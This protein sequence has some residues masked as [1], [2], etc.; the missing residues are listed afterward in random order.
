MSNADI[1]KISPFM[2]FFWE[3]QQNYLSCLSTTVR[4]HPMVIRYCLSLASKSAAA[5]DDMRYDEKTG[6]GFLI[7]PSRRS[8]R[9]Y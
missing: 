1:R 4:Y 9:D 2:K 3:E 8:L 5:Y 7:L 6:T